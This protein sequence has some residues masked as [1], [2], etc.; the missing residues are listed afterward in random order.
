MTK[1]DLCWEYKDIVRLE[2]LHMQH[3]MLIKE[4]DHIISVNEK[5]CITVLYLGINDFKTKAKNRC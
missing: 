3:I 1:L 2:N 5:K 4:K